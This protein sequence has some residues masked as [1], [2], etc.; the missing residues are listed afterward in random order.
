MA[1]SDNL[2]IILILGREHSVFH[3]MLA[4]YV[5]LFLGALS[6][7]KAVPFIPKLLIDYFFV[8]L[9]VYFLI[10][11]YWALSNAFSVSN[12]MCHVACFLYSI[13]VM[14]YTD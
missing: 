6:Q 13:S 1:R 3:M 10:M 7:L 4:S 2:V 12:V 14:Y 8:L 11:G 5:G 9:C